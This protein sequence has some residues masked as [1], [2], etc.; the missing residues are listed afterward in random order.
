M[1]GPDTSAWRSRAACRGTDPEMF[2]PVA[3]A[4]PVLERQ[5]DRA[6]WVCDGC[7]V[8]LAC[9]EWAVDSLPHGIAGGLTED[10]RQEIRR[11]RSPRCGRKVLPVVSPPR[12]R[13]PRRPLRPRWAIIADGQAALAAGT[14]RE[15]VARELGV[16]RRTV[17]RWA[18]DMTR[19]LVIDGVL[20]GGGR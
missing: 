8:Q 10:E 12:P 18:A 7:P 14:P 1:V 19:R 17:D 16:S 13:T 3:E 6:K 4:G 20:S 9:R 2:F 15:R 11:S 5:I